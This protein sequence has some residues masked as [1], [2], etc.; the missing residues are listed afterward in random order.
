MLSIDLDRKT[1]IAILSPDSALSENDFISA[2]QV[3]DPYIEEIGRLNGL[4]IN[5]KSFPGWKSFAALLKH[6]TF[7][8]EHH[9]Q[10]SHVALVTD[11]TLANLAEKIA[12]HFISAEIKQFKFSRLEEAKTWIRQTSSA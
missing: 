1:G 6:L 7:V 9:K 11:S 10:I 4:I 5:T 3:I 8:K 12:N 2:A